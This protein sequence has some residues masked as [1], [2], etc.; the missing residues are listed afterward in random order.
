MGS[1]VQSATGACCV[2]AFRR[3]QGAGI[4]IN[5]QAS[6]EG[7]PGYRGD[8][9]PPCIPGSGLSQSSVAG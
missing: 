2:R 4:A 1:E 8:G 7:K 9:S 5:G 3:T 6:T